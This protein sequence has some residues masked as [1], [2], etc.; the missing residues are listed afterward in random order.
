MP[1]RA[2]GGGRVGVAILQQSEHPLPISNVPRQMA[3]WVLPILVFVTIFINLF[4]ILT[5]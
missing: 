3:F 5:K 2:L 4:F 1:A